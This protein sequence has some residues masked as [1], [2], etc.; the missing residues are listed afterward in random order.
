MILRSN[1]SCFAIVSIVNQDERFGILHAIKFY[2]GRCSLA[3]KNYDMYDR[4]HLAIVNTMNQWHQ[5]KIFPSGWND[6]VTV[7]AVR[8]SRQRH[9]GGG[10][11]RAR[12]QYHAS[13]CISPSHRSFT[14]SSHSVGLQF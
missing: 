9:P 11:L 4:H 1:A 6:S 10:L 3:E 8:Q 7:D 14:V 2:S 13:R 12:R 5:E